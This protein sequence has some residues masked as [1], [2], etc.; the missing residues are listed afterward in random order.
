ML[1]LREVVPPLTVQT[2]DG[3]TVRA[4]DY[5]QKKNLVIAFLHSDC[6]RCRAFVEDLARHAAQLAE[7]EAVA[8]LV[9]TAPP[10]LLAAARLPEQLILG[11]E[12]GGVAHRKYFGADAIGPTGEPR[13]GVF[14]ADRYGEL[15][16]CWAARE[17]H[18]LP[19]AADVL[20]WLGQIEVAC[21][22]CGLSEWPAA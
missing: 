10:G 8:M 12:P 20:D 14:V 9:E 22:E 2:P 5:K 6:W 18:E 3:R 11:A 17:E 13:A 7:S 15:F 1:T 21:E 4:W 19:V 16:A